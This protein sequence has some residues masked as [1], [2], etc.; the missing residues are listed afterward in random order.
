MQ[1]SKARLSLGWVMGL[2][3]LGAAMGQCG[4]GS[5][6]TGT[7]TNSVSL[8]ILSDNGLGIVVSEPA[9]IQCGTAC[10]ALFPAGTT[11]TLTANVV[12]ET[13]AAFQGWGGACSG[14]TAS[15]IVQLGSGQEVTAK[16]AR[17]QQPAPSLSLTTVTPANV[18]SAGGVT[19]T[20]TG[21]GFVTGTKV[22]LDGG[23]V[24]PV[25]VVS[26]T[27]LSFS[28]PANPGKH[29]PVAIQITPPEGQSVTR[30]DLMTRY[31]S[32]VGFTATTEVPAADGPL[33]VRAVDVDADGKLDLLTPGNLLIQINLGNGDGTFK[34]ATTI[35]GA[36][37]IKELEVA[38][39]NDDKVPDIISGVFGKLYVN[40]GK[41]NLTFDAAVSYTAGANTAGL[42][43]ADLD[44]DKK[45]DVVSNDYGTSVHVLIGAGD[46]TLKTPVTYM[47][48]NPV[49]S[50]V[51]DF[52]G[53]KK[54]DLI[55]S[56]NRTMDVGFL[57]NK[58]D[59]TFKPSVDILTSQTY[60]TRVFPIDF[61]RDGKLDFF[62]A[63]ASG[64]PTLH[65]GKGNGTF[66][67]VQN[68]PVSGNA[69]S[70]VWVGDLNL[71][72]IYDVVSFDRNDEK[73][74][75]LMGK[76]GGTFGQELTYPTPALD[77]GDGG[78]AVGDFNGDK[79]PDIALAGGLG[80]SL[81]VLLNTTK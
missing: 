21:T 30:G 40:L 6:S 18:P 19:V 59:G 3:F 8:T 9:G 1:R 60:P 77:D 22:L 28:V 41:G 43:V 46:G 39:L 14:S 34:A 64:K 75:I 71:D 11:V 13:G 16:W 57:A 25:T 80:T 65:L 55:V 66:A 33:L 74:H 58:G 79:L 4:T 62:V 69:N 23:E 63:N 29:G 24:T 50:A 73:V 52:D 42:V 76:A 51:G 61:D 81:F 68:I 38:D 7:D 36:Q 54:P 78:M 49:G 56:Q 35:P 27:E 47:A 31:L 20:L 17:A 67:A 53:D 37:F 70:D 26:A 5:G 48:K 15:C 32:T 2:G 44:G 10:T 12:A 45:L 72:G